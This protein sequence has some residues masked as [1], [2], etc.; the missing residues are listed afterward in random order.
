M[1]IMPG[2]AGGVLVGI[3]VIDLGKVNESIPPLGKVPIEIAN[4]FTVWGKGF[5]FLWLPY[6]LN[7]IH[8]KGHSTASDTFIESMVNETM[9]YSL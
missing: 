5:L 3:W 7:L 2:A 6:V 4:F 1:N 8:V 9:M